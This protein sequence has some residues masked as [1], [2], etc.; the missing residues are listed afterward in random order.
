MAPTLVAG[1]VLFV[2][3][4]TEYQVGEIIV[5]SHHRRIVHRIVDIDGSGGFITKGDANPYK[6]H[7]LVYPDEIYGKVVYFFFSQIQC[8]SFAFSIHEMDQ[9]EL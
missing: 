2:M 4:Q 3:P 9:G 5:F 6:D 7:R 1:D 8:S